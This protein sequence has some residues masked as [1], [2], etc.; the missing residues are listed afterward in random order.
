MNDINQEFIKS[1]LELG[2]ELLEKDNL[3]EK[4]QKFLT[5]LDLIM[6]KIIFV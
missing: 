4:E 3:T 5:N 1:C 6:E 2:K